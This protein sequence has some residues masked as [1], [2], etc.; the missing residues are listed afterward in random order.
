MK[1]VLYVLMFI[2]IPFISNAQTSISNGNWETD[3]NWNTNN[4]PN[5]SFANIVNIQS[6]IIS[7]NNIDVLFGGIL[8]IGNNDANKDTL[9]INGELLSAIFTTI[10]VLNDGVLIISEDLYN[11]I[12]GDVYIDGELIVEGSFYNDGSSYIEVGENGIIDIDSIFFNNG[13]VIN[14]GVI[15]ADSIN[16]SGII[17]GNNPLPVELMYF[18]GENYEYYNQIKWA[19][20]SEINNDYFLI[21]YSTNGYDWDELTTIKG[22]GNSTTIKEYSYDHY[23]KIST[24]YRLLQ[25]DYNGD[26]EKFNII[27]IESPYINNDI[28][29]EVY[30]MSGRFILR[31]KYNDINLNGLYI[32]RNN[33]EVKKFYFK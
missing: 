18:N 11:V 13:I 6:N 17:Y 10:R 9:I 31:S 33:K 27:F 2:I 15:I 20:Y 23:T 24:Y 3:S 12:L 28:E 5:Y 21:E 30:D 8:N 19:T 4:A 26:N 32:I 1:K 14:D 29:Y 16:G 7:N 25:F 22:S